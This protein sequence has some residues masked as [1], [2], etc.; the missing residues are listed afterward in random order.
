MFPF[1]PCLFLSQAFGCREVYFISRPVDQWHDW[2]TYIA[3]CVMNTN[4]TR[5][6]TFL[7]GRIRVL[8]ATE[9]PQVSDL[10]PI[11]SKLNSTMARQAGQEN[12]TVFSNDHSVSSC[13]EFKRLNVENIKKRLHNYESLTAAK[14]VL[15]SMLS[16]MEKEP[17]LSKAYAQFMTAYDRLGH[18]ELLEI[19]LR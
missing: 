5:V 1:F 15:S 9:L 18:K 3:T 2:F 12:C 16:R 11:K 7:Q 14:R 13:S 10:T 8:H 19:M 4:F 6:K 17:R